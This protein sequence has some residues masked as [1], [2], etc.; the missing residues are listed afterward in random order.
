MKN[1]KKNQPQFGTATNTNKNAGQEGAENL[2]QFMLNQYG[3]DPENMTKS[4]KKAF[5]K[6]AHELLQAG[7]IGRDEYDKII[8]ALK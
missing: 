7:E 5:K 1:N 4:E 2:R 8:K 3:K 6:M